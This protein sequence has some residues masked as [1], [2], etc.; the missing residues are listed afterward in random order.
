MVIVLAC[1][2]LTATGFVIDGPAYFHAVSQTLHAHGAA[3]KPREPTLLIVATFSGLAAWL[4][5]VIH[6]WKRRQV[7][8]I[9][10]SFVLSYFAVSAY[11]VTTLI[12]T[13]R[14]VPDAAR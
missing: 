3:A 7:R 10:A 4:L 9:I 14:S 5:A 8:W 2:S 1:V 11:A 13:R 6:Q 12:R